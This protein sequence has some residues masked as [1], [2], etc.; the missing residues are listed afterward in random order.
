[1]LILHQL[2]MEKNIV[3]QR[4]KRIIPPQERARTYYRV[5]SALNHIPIGDKEI[6]LLAHAAITGQLDKPSKDAFSLEHNMKMDAVNTMIGRLKKKQMLVIEDGE[7]KANPYSRPDFTQTIKL[8]IIL[9]GEA[10]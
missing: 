1:M 9:D 7:I 5:L 4:L 3:T 6:C 8:E 10:I 2:H